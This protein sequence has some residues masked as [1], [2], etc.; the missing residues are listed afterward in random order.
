[1]VLHRCIRTRCCGCG[2]WQCFWS[3]GFLTLLVLR[4]EERYLFLPSWMHLMMCTNVAVVSVQR[5][6]EFWYGMTAT[7]LV[8][9]R[10]DH[11][12]LFPL[13]SCRETRLTTVL[14]LRIQVN[15]IIPTSTPTWSR[16]RSASP[17]SS[18]SQQPRQNYPELS[19]PQTWKQ[20]LVS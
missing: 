13:P 15:R 1:M 19:L 18:S 6:R 9:E 20:N 5:I 17:P 10:D 16:S 2:K 3:L 12:L 14:R 7:S 11:N 4:T 8:Y